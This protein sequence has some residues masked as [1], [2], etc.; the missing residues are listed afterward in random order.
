MKVRVSAIDGVQTGDEGVREFAAA[1]LTHDLLSSKSAVVVDVAGGVPGAGT[2]FSSSSCAVE[3]D[4]ES[5]F[6][7]KYY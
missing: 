4:S 5:T 1:G 7:I 2:A 3:F 6:C